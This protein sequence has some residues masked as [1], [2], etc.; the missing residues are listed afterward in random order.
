MD[1]HNNFTEELYKETDA[2]KLV[3][4]I[5]HKNEAEKRIVSM[6]PSTD[7]GVKT[8]PLEPTIEPEDD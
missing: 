5:S 7:L 3:E 8:E 4:A 2:S 1:K 6:Q